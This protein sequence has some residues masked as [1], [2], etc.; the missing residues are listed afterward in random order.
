MKYRTQFSHAIP[1]YREIT[2]VIPCNFLATITNIPFYSCLWKRRSLNLAKNIVPPP[3]F[4]LASAAC[5]P[6]NFRRFERQ[7]CSVSKKEKKGGE[8]KKASTMLPLSSFAFFSL[9]STCIYHARDFVTN[10]IQK[11][12]RS[13]V[14]V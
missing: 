14:R 4:P 13:Y 1:P 11:F 7:P 5:S 2:R 9:P 10:S 8:E 3:C 12:Y 6:K